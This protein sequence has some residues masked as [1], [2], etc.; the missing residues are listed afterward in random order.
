MQVSQAPAMAQEAGSE[1]G[2]TWGSV[3]AMSAWARSGG[4]EG[5][6]GWQRRCLWLPTPGHQ[7][8]TGGS[9]APHH[10]GPVAK[11]DLPQDPL[12]SQRL[13]EA[14]EQPDAGMSKSQEHSSP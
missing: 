8:S 5:K 4:G 6:G 14:G 10:V 7:D 11:G 2:G 13:M 1:E 3:P 12:V 9:R